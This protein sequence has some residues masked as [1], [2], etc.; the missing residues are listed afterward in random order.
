MESVAEMKARLGI[1]EEPMHIQTDGICA[2]CGVEPSRLLEHHIQWRPFEMTLPVCEPCH[3]AIHDKP[4]LEYYRPDWQPS[5]K[6]RMRIY[7]ARRYYKD[8]VGY[9][10]KVMEYYFAHRDHI[11][12]K[13]R[14]WQKAHPGYMA[15]ATRKWEKRNPEKVKA[16]RESEACRRSTRESQRRYRERMHSTP[17]GRAIL[18][19]RDKVQNDRAAAK[20][21]AAK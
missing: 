15:A 11:Y 14:E 18:R 17:E 7:R 10:A 16:Y 19:A 13:G 3:H 9:N 5:Y 20:R 12:K 8:P 6:E 21:R 2:I 1:T 4:G